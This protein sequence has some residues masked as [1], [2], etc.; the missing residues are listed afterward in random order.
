ML[1]A[2]QSLVR[3]IADKMKIWTIARELWT[4]AGE[5]PGRLKDFW[6]IAAERLA[7][8]GGLADEPLNPQSSNGA[9]SA[10]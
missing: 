7:A 4:E 8:E 10:H 3:P 5:P 2:T 1:P 9:S 6:E